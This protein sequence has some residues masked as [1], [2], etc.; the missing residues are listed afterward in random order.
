VL[1]REPG[2]LVTVVRY[3]ALDMDVGRT[4]RSLFLHGNTVRYRLHKAEELLG[5]CLSEVAV[6]AN[7]YLALQDEIAADR[8][9]YA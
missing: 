6:V 8:A 7:L 5:G 9:R 1:R 4:A 3:L 2:L